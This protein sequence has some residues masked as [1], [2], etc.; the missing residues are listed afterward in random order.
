MSSRQISGNTGISRPSASRS[1]N[2]RAPVPGRQVP[3]H[4]SQRRNVGPSSQRRHVLGERE[5]RAS[6][7]R[8]RAGRVPGATKAAALYSPAA[9]RS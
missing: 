7:D 1:G 6:C 3:V 9:S 2:T 4:G 5:R 8:S